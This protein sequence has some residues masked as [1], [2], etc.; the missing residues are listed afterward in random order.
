M[1]TDAIKNAYI[2]ILREEL[3]PATGCTEPIALAYAAARLRDI[4]GREP[5]RV[6]AEVSGNMLKNVKS[7]VVPGTGGKK[8]IPAAIAAGVVA[9]DAGKVLQVI[10]DV[11]AEKH[12]TIAAYMGDVPIEVACSDTTRILDIRLTGWAGEHTALVHIA[13]SHSN[14]VREERD[15]TVLLER[16]VTDSAEDSLTDK[17]VL[18]VAD[19]LEFA[20][21]V[22]LDQ[23]SEL[24][25]RQLS[26]NTAIAEE[27]L[28]NSWGANIGSILLRDYPK[29]IKTEAKAWAAAGSDARM[30]GCEM[31]VVIL[32]GSGNQGITASVPLARYAQHLGASREKLYR[33]LLVSDLVTVHQKSGIGRLSAYCGA[34][35]AGVGAGAGIAYLLDGSF[36]AVAHTIVNAVAIISGTICDGAKPSCAAKIAASVDAGILGYHMYRGGQEFKG[37]DGIVTKGVDNT[38]ANIGILAKEGMRQTDRTILE[39]MTDRCS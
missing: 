8:G 39:I 7:V 20:D 27:G 11:P 26:C 6:L 35:S 31:P 18:K 12:C 30:S 1:L 24:L 4:L 13:N 37:G 9:G 17:S 32:S 38:I 21:T 22:E 16:P 10:A 23:V 33:A 29:D 14:I 25:E 19:I 5:E 28:R 2:S 36:E 34:V 3:M 15:G